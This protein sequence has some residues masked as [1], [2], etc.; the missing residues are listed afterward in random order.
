MWVSQVS[1]GRKICIARLGSMVKVRVLA[2]GVYWGLGLCVR[3]RSKTVEPLP[4]GGACVDQT[5]GEETMGLRLR[6]SGY[7]MSHETPYTGFDP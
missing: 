3:P 6:L 4:P 7:V 2:R 5:K 1:K